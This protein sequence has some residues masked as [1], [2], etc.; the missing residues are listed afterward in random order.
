MV[1]TRNQRCR[2][3][4]G[5]LG[6]TRSYCGSGGAGGCRSRGHSQRASRRGSTYV[7]KKLKKLIQSLTDR[8][9]MNSQIEL[10]TGNAFNRCNYRGRTMTAVAMMTSEL[11]A[12]SR[13]IAPE[14]KTMSIV[15]ASDGSESAFAAF[16]AATLIKARNNAEIHVLTVL[17]PMPAMFPSVEGIIIPVELD[18]SREEA[19]RTTVLEQMMPYDPASE[20]SLDIRL[21][22]AAESIV[23]FAVESKADL[24]IVGLHRHG[25][26]GRL[27]GE[28]TAMA[29]ARLSPVPLLVASPGMK[30]LPHRV[31]VAMDL[32]PD[33]LQCAPEALAAIANTP[34][35]SCV[36]VKPRSEFLGV[37]WVEFDR[38]YELAMRER[39]S[40]LENQL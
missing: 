14:P 17:E 15:V 22:R 34:S 23:D 30:R 35:I 33:G 13:S 4:D 3:D 32:R 29:I 1:G 31:M 11:D 6:F 12:R 27:L 8:L 28:E 5:G 19:Q 18:R 7:R 9:G 36:H 10:N 16:K 38:D 40:A 26:V 21:G 20:W 24:I 2:N 37:D 25:I 39:F